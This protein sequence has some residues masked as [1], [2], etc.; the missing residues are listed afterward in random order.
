MPHFLIKSFDI[1]DNI[2]HLQDPDTVRHLTGALRVQTGEIVKFIDENKIQYEAEILNFSKKEVRAKVLKSA[3]SKRE[4]QYNL[5]LAQSILKTDA[6]N[7]Y[8]LELKEHTLLYP[9][10]QQ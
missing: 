4:L 3:I 2:V 5:F 10:I 9:I 6:Q 1:K 8:S 7:P